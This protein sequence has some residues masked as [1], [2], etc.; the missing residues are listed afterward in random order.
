M[1]NPKKEKYTPARTPLKSRNRIPRRASSAGVAAL[2]IL[3]SGCVVP[4]EGNGPEELPGAT[5]TTNP[6]QGAENPSDAIAETIT[7][8]TDLGSDL[9]IEIIALEN[10]A[11]NILRL[12][13][14]ITNKSPNPFSLSN[15]LAEER[16]ANTASNITLIDAINQKRYLSYDLSNGNCFCSTPL[17]GPIQSGESEELWVA[18]PG[19]ADDIESMSIIMPL[20]PPILDVP[21]S[22]S[23]ESLEN[24]SIG[25]DQ[26]LDLTLISDG[27][28][29]QTGRTETGEEVSIILS[30]DVLFDTNSAELSPEAREILE[31][32]A[33]EIDDASS[34]VVNIDG[35]ADNRGTDAANTP[36][37]ENRASAV[38]EIL[39]ELVTREGVRF[40]SAGHG[41]SEPIADNSTEEGRERNR[42]VSVT[43]EK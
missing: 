26:I 18:Y 23:T 43:F 16:D 27:L 19:P 40:E 2:V 11:N 24:E 28:E 12:R 41:S 34:T 38:E 3:V 32:V 17:S 37:S 5:P 30:S 15:G 33:Q 10:L 25:A 4:S 21:I 6:E 42:R 9:R 22:E 8:T 13:I 1:N 31:Q 14:R 39:S 20:A 36:L 35:H 7:T 29:D